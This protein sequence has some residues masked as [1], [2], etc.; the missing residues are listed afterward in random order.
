MDLDAIIAA[1]SALSG[2]ELEAV[3]EAVARRHQT[4][5][6]STVVERRSYGSGILPLGSRGELSAACGRALLQPEILPTPKLAAR[7]PSFT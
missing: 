5:A 1:I 4:L 6:Q 2:P 7:L 3:R